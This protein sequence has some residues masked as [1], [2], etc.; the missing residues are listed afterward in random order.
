MAGPSCYL[1]FAGN[2]QALLPLARIEAIDD[3]R[4]FVLVDLRGCYCEYAHG[5][6]V[7]YYYSPTFNFT[8]TD[9]NAA[10][11]AHRRRTSRPR[12]CLIAFALA[13]TLIPELTKNDKTWI[14]G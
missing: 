1:F 5:G 13:R 9:T 14:P 10:T 8:K 4:C 11:T 2:R 6:R 7:R 3:C 12:L